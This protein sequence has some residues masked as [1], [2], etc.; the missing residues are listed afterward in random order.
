MVDPRREFLAHFK[1]RVVDFDR[2][3]DAIRHVDA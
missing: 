1:E 2:G 3:L